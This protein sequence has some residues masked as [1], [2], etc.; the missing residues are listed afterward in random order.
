[1]LYEWYERLGR[2]TRGDRFKS[3]CI[4]GARGTGKTGF[5]NYINGGDPA[6]DPS[7]NDRVIYLRGVMPCLNMTDSPA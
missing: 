6:L 2:Y 7:G 3:L 1:M 4:Y 5:I